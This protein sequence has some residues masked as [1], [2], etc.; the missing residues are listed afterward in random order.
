MIAIAVEP[1]SNPMT[2]LRKNAEAITWCTGE[3]G[4]CKSVEKTH[5]ESMNV[6]KAAPSMKYSGQ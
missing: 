6:A 5:A 1:I 3:A 4:Y 2:H